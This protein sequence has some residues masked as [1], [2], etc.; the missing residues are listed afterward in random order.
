MLENY[1]HFILKSAGCVL[2]NYAPSVPEKNS[3]ILRV[4]DIQDMRKFPGQGSNLCIEVTQATAVT[5]QDP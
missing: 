1:S 2:S 5:M 4:G 3:T